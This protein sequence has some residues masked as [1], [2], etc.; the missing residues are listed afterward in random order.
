VCEWGVFVCVCGCVCGGCVSVCKFVRLFFVV[1]HLFG[2]G[3]NE[4]EE[5][6]VEQHN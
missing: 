4:R 2:A 5:K 3:C 6:V 1:F